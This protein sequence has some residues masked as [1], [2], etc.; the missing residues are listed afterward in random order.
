MHNLKNSKS[1]CNGCALPRL[2]P[3]IGE[4][5]YKKWKENKERIKRKKKS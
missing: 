2:A 4:D 5:D 3:K 1:E